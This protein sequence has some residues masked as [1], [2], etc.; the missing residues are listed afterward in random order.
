MAFNPCY[1]STANLQKK[2][3]MCNTC[4]KKNVFFLKIFGSLKKK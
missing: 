2:Y 3:D 4:K 1:K